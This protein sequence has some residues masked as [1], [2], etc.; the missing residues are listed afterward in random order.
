MPL[1]NK[2]S[3][4]K[5]FIN[6]LKQAIEEKTVPKIFSTAD[7]RRTFPDKE[8]G[9]LSNYD[10]GNAGSSNKNRKRL[11]SRPINGRKYYVFDE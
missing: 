6:R 11:S 5:P 7:V 4:K 10:K 8:A 1:V 3:V 2:F 9:N